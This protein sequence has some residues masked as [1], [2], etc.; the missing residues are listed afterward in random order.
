MIKIVKHGLSRSRIYRTWQ[1]MRYRCQN[2]NHTAYDSYGAKGISVC[3]EWDKSFISFKNW[4]FSNG[5][6]DKLTIDIKNGLGNYEP[7]NCRWVDYIGQNTNLCQLKNNTSG[8]K[9]ISWNK[10]REKW[11]CNI[12]IKN[13]TKHI[14]DYETIELAAKA[15]NEFI[16]K[17]NLPHQKVCIEL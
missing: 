16:D 2:K 10:K 11:R 8:Y 15:R 14:G 6:T 3:E 17:N 9:G 5:Y 1:S 7:D 12:S 13:K 4:A